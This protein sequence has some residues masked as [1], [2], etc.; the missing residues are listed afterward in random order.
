M[1]REEVIISN[2]NGLQS[3]KM[4]SDRIMAVCYVETVF[5]DERSGRER[6]K[7]GTGFLSKLNLEGDVFGV[8]TNHHVLG[9]VAEAGNAEATFGYEGSSAGEKV[10]LRP[11]IMFRTQKELDYTF[12]GVNKQ[13]LDSLQQRVEP[14]PIAPEPELRQEDSVM[15]FQHPKGRRK[16]YSQDKIISIEKPFVFYQADTETG[17]SGSPVLTAVGLKLIAIHHKGSEEGGYNKGTLIS[18][19]LMHLEKETYTKPSGSISDSQDREIFE[20]MP[21]R[22]R[23]RHDQEDIE[24][25][26][27]S[28]EALGDLA[29]H[30]TP[31]WKPLGRKL[32]VP[33]AKLEEIQSDNV[34]YPAV[35]EKAFQMLMMSSSVSHASKNLYMDNAWLGVVGHFVVYVL[36]RA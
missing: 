32:K 30:I 13:D 36:W 12:V 29:Q 1:E 27:P 9:T 6:L 35:K 14:I 4:L 17:S 26:M 11:E 25:G 31:F 20:D 18:E 28:E 2:G 8:F 7:R 22:K 34:Q 5:R 3:T 33:N 16:E 10:K 15:I 21:P 24:N 23:P 19:V